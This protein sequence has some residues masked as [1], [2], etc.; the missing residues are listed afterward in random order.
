VI[1]GT[2][3]VIDRGEVYV[4]EG[5][6]TKVARQV[7]SAS[8]G[9]GTRILDAGG[10]TV[11][12]GLMDIHTH[13]P[14]RHVHRPMREYQ[15]DVAKRIESLPDEQR[16]V[17]AIKNAWTEMLEGV[18]TFRDAGAT[19]ALNNKLR[20]VFESKLLNGPRIVS[21]GQAITITGG[22]GTLRYVERP[23]ADGVD[24]IK[25]AVRY[26]LRLGADWIKLAASG[27]LQ[28]MPDYEDP[29]WTEFD[30]E[31][32]NVAVHEAHKRWARVCAHTY[33]PEAIQNCIRAGVDS[34]EHGSKLDEETVEMMVRAG[35]FYVPTMSAMHNVWKREEGVGNTK[36]ADLLREVVVEPHPESVAMAHRAGV[37][38]ATGTD[39]P[40][41]IVQELEMLHAAG[42][43]AME[44]IRAATAVAAEVLGMHDRLGTI[45]AAKYA[46]LVIV[47][48]NPLEDLGAF[49]RVKHVIKDGNVVTPE[50]LLGTI[51]E[52]MGQPW[53]IA[54][55]SIYRA[56][57]ESTKTA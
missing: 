9:A 46:D 45:E 41:Q 14:R 56:R 8:L 18:T 39:T 47:D 35:T 20:W 13:L 23:G 43:P 50:W 32:M 34:I 17:W 21:C 36:F 51:E 2:G 1:D 37:R 38:I 6:V 5:L 52:A 44:C 27:G 57:P 33:Y 49:R 10:G 15:R 7:N 53:L 16:I 11:V 4:E 3:A 26:Q 48:G 40:G 25:K 54:E 55:K 19:R 24:E 42:I 31:E 12:P 22:H 30:L 29:R 28:G